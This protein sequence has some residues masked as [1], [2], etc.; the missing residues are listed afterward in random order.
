MWSQIGNHA[1][2]EGVVIQ[3]DVVSGTI[4]ETDYRD[5]NFTVSGN[6]L[7]ITNF[8]TELE[9]DDTLQFTIDDFSM[10]QNHATFTV[11]N[12]KIDSASTA[13][14]SQSSKSTSNT[15]TSS[16]ASSSANS[17]TNTASNNTTTNGTANNNT[18]Q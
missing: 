13:A 14:S 15:N 4:A 11:K 9:N 2:R 12:V 8:I 7:A 3:I 1:T 18:V 17:N 10:T 16:N 5:L 6:Y